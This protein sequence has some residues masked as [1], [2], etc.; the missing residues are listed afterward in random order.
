MLEGFV[1]VYD[2]KGTMRGG[3]ASSSAS[4]KPTQGRIAPLV[5]HPSP[6][7]C[8]DHTIRV[9]LCRR[10]TNAP[11]A[12]GRTPHLV[13]ADIWFELSSDC[14][15]G[16]TKSKPLPCDMDNIYREPPLMAFHAKEMFNF[17]QEQRKKETLAPLRSMIFY[18]DDWRRPRTGP[19]YDP[20][21]FEG[22]KDKFE[23]NSMKEDGTPKEPDDELYARVDVKWVDDDDDS[24]DG[25]G[26]SDS[27]GDHRA[28][29]F[30]EL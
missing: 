4:S 22:E 30:T 12:A 6:P 9:K 16:A 8:Q 29:R 7:K 20:T 24:G 17:V 1:A 5:L 28:T 27:D 25:L 10:F 3:V 13:S 15:R 26:S 19:I 18:D 21:W 11:S 23:C 14:V 2:D